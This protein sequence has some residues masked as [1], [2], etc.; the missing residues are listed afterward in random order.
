MI[1]DAKILDKFIV[2]DSVDEC[3]SDLFNW[4]DLSVFEKFFDHFDDP[5]LDFM[6]FVV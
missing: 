3:E 6:V 2:V 1:F 5:L 4:F